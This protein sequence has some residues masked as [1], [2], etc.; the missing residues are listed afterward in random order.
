MDS[1]EHTAAVGLEAVLRLGV[2]YPADSVSYYL[3]NVNVGLTA[4]LAS[5]DDLAGRYHC[6]YCDVGVFILRQEI[7]EDGI[8]DLVCHLVGVSLGHGFRRE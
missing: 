2:A 6:L 3:L 8:T 5:H 7:V 1:R 4:H